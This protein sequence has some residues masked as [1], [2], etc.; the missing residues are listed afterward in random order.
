MV[1]G[2]STRIR[3]NS[4]ATQ[5]RFSGNR[6][7]LRL[8]EVMTRLSTGRTINKAEDGA[9]K[10]SIATKMDARVNGLNVALNNVGDAKSMLNIADAGYQQT[11]DQLIE[12]KT[13]ATRAASDSIGDQEREFIGR[14][15]EQIGNEINTIANQSVYQDIELLNGKDTA[16]I[17]PKKMTIQAGERSGDE[18]TMEL[19]PVNLTKL[20]EG[21]NHLIGTGSRSYSD[22]QFYA[23]LWEI[24][25]QDEFRTLSGISSAGDLSTNMGDTAEKI[26]IDVGG[27]SYITTIPG[28]TETPD[29][30]DLSTIESA[31][32]TSGV[33]GLS[34]SVE[35]GELNWINTS[36]ET[37]TVQLVNQDDDNIGIT[38]LSLEPAEI[39]EKV[40]I[41]EG[42][43]T[44]EA[45]LTPPQSG[46]PDLQEFVNTIT[47]MGISGLYATLFEGSGT[48]P[49]RLGVHSTS[50]E[51]IN[52]EFINSDGSISTIDPFDILS[53]KANQVQI[54]G[55]GGTYTSPITEYTHLPG[56]EIMAE[57]EA[58]INSLELEGYWA[59]Y[60]EEFDRLIINNV[61][62]D[63]YT[64][65]VTSTTPGTPGITSK[66]SEPPD[67]LFP[68]GKLYFGREG[69]DLASGDDFRMFIREVDRAI[70]DM[71]E[72]MANLGS[73]QKSLTNREE[74]L[75]T[76]I[77]SNSSAHSRI[78]D[79]DFAR[80]QSRFIR[81]QI[82]QETTNSMLAQ[83]NFAPRSVMGLIE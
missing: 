48:D 78:M 44:H 16:Y 75:S 54:T 24:R 49:D 67:E 33:P 15:M 36:N 4:S 27:S 69:A 17:H 77:I 46:E 43:T 65:N 64:L 76:S 66:L 30:S 50:F 1:F 61:T 37:V 51:D 41:T 60:D 26:L 82:L 32:N 38:P 11:V 58:F 71:N 59:D 34:A 7:N 55:P 19:S 6:L 2:D 42:G 83:A 28:Y 5:A 25:Q 57:Y 10:Y 23:G 68:Q 45:N 40:R 80:E 18:V 73:T 81:L 13:L 20:F 79:A 9:A 74:L 53:P 56:E 8:G 12:L 35:N 21:S 22:N 31:V 39:I 47:D 14:Q 3:T 72:K 63:Q 29:S 62:E 52:I 70:E